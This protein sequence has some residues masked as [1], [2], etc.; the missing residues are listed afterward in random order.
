M[1][2]NL[3]QAAGA[4]GRPHDPLLRAGRRNRLHPLPSQ[5]VRLVQP[6]AHKVV[7]E[8]FSEVLPVLSS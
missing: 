3:L 5:L 4:A 6:T 1:T 8:V 7:S 2:L